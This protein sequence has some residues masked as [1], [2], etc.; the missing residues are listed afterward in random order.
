[1]SSRHFAVAEK[2]ESRRGLIAR[3]G[4]FRRRHRIEVRSVSLV[5]AGL[6]LFSVFGANISSIVKLLETHA[7]YPANNYSSDYY[8]NRYYP[9]TLTLFDYYSDEEVK[10]HSDSSTSDSKKNQNAIFNTALYESGYVADAGTWGSLHY[11]PLYVGSQFPKQYGNAYSNN[12]MILDK[13]NAY[14]YSIIANSQAESGTSAATVGLV[15]SKLSNGQLVQGDSTVTKIL[16]YF[17]EEFLKTSVSGLLSAQTR[18]RYGL[19]DSAKIGRV[20]HGP[21]DEGYT[22]NFRK[23]TDGYY[24]YISYNNAFTNSKITGTKVRYDGLSYSDGTFTVTAPSSSNLKLDYLDD[25]PGFF[26][27]RYVND[28]T[29]AYN[30]NVNYSYGALFEIPFTMSDNGCVVERDSQ[31]NI[32]GTSNTP[33]TFEFSGDDDVWVFVDDYLV[34]DVGG[35][36]GK[37]TGSVN[38]KYDPDNNVFPTS[39]TYKYKG[40]ANTG[41]NIYDQGYIANCNSY[42]TSSMVADNYTGVDLSPLYDSTKVNLYGDSGKKHTLR[43]YYIER[44]MFESNCEISFNFQLSDMISIENTVD[45]ED[46]NGVLKDKTIEAAKK[47]AVQY[48]VASN[49]AQ[50]AVN[51]PDA[52]KTYTDDVTHRIHYTVSFNTDDAD[53]GTGHGTIKPKSVFQGESITLPSSGTTYPGYKLAGWT[54]NPDHTTGPILTGVYTPTSDITLYAVYE[55]IPPAPLDIPKPPVMV[56]VTSDNMSTNGM[57]IPNGWNPD[58]CWFLQTNASGCVATVTRSINNGDRAKGYFANLTKDVSPD[59]GWG[60]WLQIHYISG[61]DNGNANWNN[62]QYPRDGYTDL[63]QA[64]GNVTTGSNLNLAYEPAYFVWDLQSL[65]NS[66]VVRYTSDSG[67]VANATSGPDEWAKKYYALY[68]AL[69]T[70]QSTYGTTRDESVRADYESWLNYYY[71]L[72]YTTSAQDIQN[73]IDEIQGTAVGTKTYA[74]STTDTV[75]FYIYSPDTPTVVSSNSYGTYTDG[76][77]NDRSYTSSVELVSTPPT[78]HVEPSGASGNYYKVTVPKYVVETVED[79]GTVLGT[80]NKANNIT[81]TAGSGSYTLNKTAEELEAV[82]SEYPCWYAEND[83]LRDIVKA[84]NFTD[85]TLIWI[86]STGGA[87]TVTYTNTFSSVSESLTAAHDSSDPDNY[88]Y[89][90]VYTKVTDFTTTQDT[91]ITINSGTA[92]ASSSVTAHNPPCYYTTTSEWKSLKTMVVEPPSWWASMQLYISQ[93]SLQN[94]WDTAVDMKAISVNSHTYYYYFVPSS[95]STTFVLRWMGSTATD[96]SGKSED[97]VGVTGDKYYHNLYNNANDSSGIV[98]IGNTDDISSSSN[99]DFY[100]YTAT[101]KSTSRLSANPTQPTRSMH[102]P[103]DPVDE[104]PDNGDDTKQDPAD[105]TK[106]DPVDDTKQDPVDDTKQD[107]VDDTKQDPADDTAT[108]PA[109]NPDTEAAHSDGVALDGQFVNAD[110]ASTKT[111]ITRNFDVADNVNYKFYPSTDE[112]VDSD[113]W[114]YAVRR[115][116]NDGRFN[117]LPDQMARFTYQFNRGSYIKIAQTGNSFR[118]K[119]TDDANDPKVITKGHTTGTT[120]EAAPAGTYSDNSTST[121]LFNRYSTTY[122]ITDENKTNKGE[123]SSSP[124]KRYTVANPNLDSVDPSPTGTGSQ[125]SSLLINDLHSSARNADD[126]VSLTVTFNNKVRVG[127]LEISK[128]L[129]QAA[130]NAVV[131]KKSSDSSYDP[132][133]YFAVD[134]YNIFGDPDSG[135]VAYNGTFYYSTDGGTTYTDAKNT[136][137]DYSDGKIPIKFSDIYEYNSTSGKWVAKANN[138]KVKITG[139]PV[140]TK[141]TLT[142][143]VDHGTTQ[144]PPDLQLQSATQVNKSG[145]STTT[146]NAT[147]NVATELQITNTINSEYDPVDYYPDTLLM[148]STESDNNALAAVYYEIDED[149]DDFTVTAVNDRQVGEYYLIIRKTIDHMYYNTEQEEDQTGDGKS[150]TDGDDPADLMSRFGINT[151]D[152]SKNLTVGDGTSWADDVNG[153]QSAT[154]AEQ[155]FIFMI[156]EY[157]GNQLVQ[158]FYET[159]SFTH[160]KTNP[161]SSIKQKERLVKVNGDHKYVVTELTDWSWK[162]KPVSATVN[163]AD[164]NSADTTNYDDV[165]VNPGKY[166]TDS[167]TTVLIDGVTEVANVHNWARAAFTDHKEDQSQT[168]RNVE[169]DTSIKRNNITVKAAG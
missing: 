148:T 76:Y 121:V 6:M 123:A 149:S 116:N 3:F 38:F 151:T 74:Y 164:G 19:S 145:D 27:T 109:E 53:G 153:Y 79:N 48:V 88:Y 55:E 134:F 21:D 120:G 68:D 125:G 26:P 101:Y 99:S 44:G 90:K 70:F 115:T 124:T 62:K 133:F 64:G 93:G 154:D 110:T 15:K 137:H 111:N 11:V 157:N 59:T 35:A 138:Y 40:N 34:L 9:T 91:T 106:Q 14:K 94:T 139:I 12:Q 86:Y 168:K 39:T 102:I 73:K 147:T 57:T 155:S 5:L 16:P 1:M 36:H 87:P 112:T 136:A 146:V 152:Y 24:R 41:S 65:T 81:I 160:D 45:A 42:S 135:S 69:C 100:T 33:I 71:N 25:K 29:P 17:D 83:I 82:S 117:L 49:S 131:D 30:S 8:T 37:V 98:R 50:S 7:S 22:F 31:G 23:D 141:Y 56:Y 85:P 61:Y 92:T 20:D 167:T 52:G 113:Y 95:G 128:T 18:A 67:R 10:G 158:T 43:V 78:G 77:A 107:P 63:S 104:D 108:D 162:Y 32:T 129:S 126:N 140:C 89:A 46:V 105:D 166:N 119:E 28:A 84:Y 142:E 169:G 47:E 159:I 75:D 122:T 118:Y 144:S 97:I 132:I 163:P 150:G 51:S 13:G 80:Y 127:T 156:Q 58:D 4:R 103:V 143:T 54:T 66:R 2:K 72:T 114:D 165:T 60:M 96:N 130:F 161:A